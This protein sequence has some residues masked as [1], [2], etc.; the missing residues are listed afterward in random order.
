MENRITFE[1][2][3]NYPNK[4]VNKK[5]YNYTERNKQDLARERRC[6]STA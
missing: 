1:Y 6:I 2:N 5:I 3:Q 4:Y